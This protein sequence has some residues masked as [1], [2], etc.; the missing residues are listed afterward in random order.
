M[1]KIKIIENT[2]E[3]VI[4][5]K[6]NLF[7]NNSFLAAGI[8]SLIFIIFF[9]EIP[10]I[11]FPIA[12]LIAFLMSVDN[13]ITIK[14]KSDFVSV[15]SKFDSWLLKKTVNIPTKD[16][17]QVYVKEQK[18]IDEPSE[19]TLHAKRSR[20]KATIP[21]FNKITLKNAKEAQLIEEKIQTFLGIKDFQIHGEFRGNLRKPLRA[22]TP[23]RQVKERNPTQ[24]NIKDLEVGAFL[25]YELATWE[26]VYQ[27]QYD[28]ER[29]ITE[30]Q[31]QLSNHKGQSMLLFVQIH[32]K[33][34]STWSESKI[35]YHDLETYKLRDILYSP[36]TQLTFKDQLYFRKNIATG[37]KF[38]PN[39][40][41]GLDVKQWHY[42]TADEK[43]SLRILQYE[44]KG[45]AA[46]SGKKIEEF[47]LENILTS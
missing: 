41:E 23:I 21:F 1:G 16:L 19:Y 44:G 32:E 8:A 2:D 4:E 12:F 45:W 22:N 30:I 28:W 29:R 35:S 14:V 40:R 47:E 3:L 38:I 27:I 33:H 36:P 10:S 18:K 17:I 43:D 24:L 7:S 25:D 5:H 20:G 46:F 15:S 9:Y 39:E 31:Y 6:A 13:K 37:K 26:V 34:P 11:T 42:I